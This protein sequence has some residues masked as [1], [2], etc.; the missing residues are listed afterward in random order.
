MRFIKQVYFTCI[1]K[2]IREMNDLLCE[3]ILSQI[4]RRHIYECAYIKYS[5]QCVVREWVSAV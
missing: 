3:T 5:H 2:I 1:A 4:T